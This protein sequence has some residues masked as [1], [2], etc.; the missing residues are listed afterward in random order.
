MDDKAFDR[1]VSAVSATGTSVDDAVT[2]ARQRELYWK[3]LVELK[4]GASYIRRYRERQAGWHT[5]IAAIRAIAASSTIAG[6]VIWKNY[7]I[8]WAGIIAS[9]QVV[10]ALQDVFPFSKRRKAASELTTALDGLFIDAQFEW[11][12]VTAGSYTAEEIMTRRQK[13]MTLRLEAESKHFPDGLAI[14]G[15]LFAVAKGD[16]QRYLSDTYGEDPVQ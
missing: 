10:D 13:L 6:W 14:D 12:G 1:P 16:A 11:E 5:R 8:V 7:A 3:E 2:R 15:K 9:S 4:V